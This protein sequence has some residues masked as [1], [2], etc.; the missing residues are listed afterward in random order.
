MKECKVIHINDN[1]AIWLEKSEDGGVLH[2][3]RL[4]EAIN[5]FLLKGY[6][7]KQ[8][9][10]QYRAGDPEEV[11]DF[12]RSGFTVYLERELSDDVDSYISNEDEAF[13][14]DDFAC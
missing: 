13:E 6:E 3:P 5:R 12:Y 9:I 8:I 2:Y 4:E 7:V 10:Q 14:D 1:G 11:F